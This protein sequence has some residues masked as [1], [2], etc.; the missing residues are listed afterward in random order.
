MNI[1]ISGFTHFFFS[2]RCWF[3]RGL[4]SRSSFQ[5]VLALSLEAQ[6]RYWVL[7]HMSPTAASSPAP[8]F[9]WCLGPRRRWPHL[10]PVPGSKNQ[11]WVK[12]WLPTLLLWVGQGGSTPRYCLDRWVMG[13]GI[14]EKEAKCL[15]SNWVAL[16][17]GKEKCGHLRGALGLGWMCVHVFFLSVHLCVGIITHVHM[18]FCDSICTYLHL[19]AYM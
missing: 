8:A 17:D 11:G 9:P 13:V 12:R 4:V 1:V 3:L 18:N 2:W 6:K 5:L 15:T 19:F 10:S 16:W 14:P 7:E